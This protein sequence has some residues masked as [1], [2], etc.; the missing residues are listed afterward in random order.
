MHRVRLDVRGEIGADRAL[1]RLLGIGGTHHFT[2]LGN[3]VVA[4]EHLDHHRPGDHEL[5][6]VLEERAP[7]VH[8]V[9][10]LGLGARKVNHPGRRDLQ[11]GT[12]EAS[13]DLADHILGN[14]VG[15]DD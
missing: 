7:A 1:R 14:G 6:Q 12:L 5:D 11:P 2:I 9:E 4:F 10:R 15:F 8:S 3:R 13:V